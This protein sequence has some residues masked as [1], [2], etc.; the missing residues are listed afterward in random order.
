M[1]HPCKV[2]VGLEA[3]C[4]GGAKLFLT[5]ISSLQPER[6]NYLFF[7]IAISF[8]LGLNLFE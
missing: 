7:S 8:Y 4:P 5:Q 6:I 1:T 2:K 3:F